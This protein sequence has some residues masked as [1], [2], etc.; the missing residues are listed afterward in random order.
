MTQKELAEEKLKGML[1][2]AD[3]PM[4]ASYC[5]GEVCRIFGI[6]ERTFWRLVAQYELDE[7]GRLKRPDCLNSFMLASNRRVAYPELVA[8]LVRNNTY[9]R[10]MAIDPNQMDLFPEDTLKSA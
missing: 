3:M 6:V 9:T 2:A 7:Q 1:T 8:F 10:Q 5:T 4:K